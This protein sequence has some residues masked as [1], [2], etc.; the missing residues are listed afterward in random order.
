MDI[1][2]RTYS[3]SIMFAIHVGAMVVIVTLIFLC[4]VSWS[5]IAEEP[6]IIGI[7]VTLLIL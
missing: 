4:A 5:M 1:S 7:E 6:S 2:R 3:V